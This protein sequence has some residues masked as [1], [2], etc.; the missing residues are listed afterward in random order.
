MI[1]SVAGALATAAVVLALLPACA[2]KEDFKSEV[3]GY[4]NQTERLARSYT[5]TEVHGGAQLAVSVRVNDDLTYSA[6][7]TE[8]GAAAASEVVVD[9][10]RALRISDTALLS[11]LTAAP[12]SAAQAGA[13]AAAEATNAPKASA[14]PSPQ[15][16]SA[17]RS[18]QW[19]FD[20]SGG[21]SLVKTHRTRALQLG[22]DPVGDALGVMAYF[23]RLLDSVSSPQVAKFNPEAG[24][25]YRDLDPFPWPAAGVT[26]Y[27]INASP[28]LPPRNPLQNQGN[29][30][31]QQLQALRD[32]FRSAAVYVRG[33]VIVALRESIDVKRRLQLP[34]QDI[35]YRLR[36]GGLKVP[37]AI[38]SAS[39]SDQAAFIVKTLN[40]F[41]QSTSSDLLRERQL[42]T[43]L[44]LQKRAA[45]ITIPPGVTNGILT[46]VFDRGQVLGG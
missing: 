43:E 11:G 17:L 24:T 9:D 45:P 36:D 32:Y 5:Y 1:R 15:T 30:A 18:G 37:A 29:Q 39:L 4:L 25:Y 21:R 41:Y 35:L 33:G 14:G 34:D 22:Q 26:R 2:L 13:A 7:L 44:T 40:G 20:P 3:Q 19:V 46:G 12:T 10:G 6:D 42:D 8:N 28:Q 23:Q 16:L 38:F 31:Q 27:D